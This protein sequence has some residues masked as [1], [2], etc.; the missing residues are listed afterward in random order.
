MATL[1]STVSTGERETFKRRIQE[2]VLLK[3]NENAKR[4]DD[5]KAMFVED[6]L[7]CNYDFIPYCLF[8][9]IALGQ[10]CIP[11]FLVLL[12]SSVFTLQ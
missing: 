11:L 1:S 5:R 4:V 10:C 6:R 8:L 7:F 2:D 9:S 3:H 12:H